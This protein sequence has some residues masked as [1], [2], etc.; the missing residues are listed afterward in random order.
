MSFSYA[1]S[2]SSHSTLQASAIW[3]GYPANSTPWR[4]EHMVLWCSLALAGAPTLLWPRHSWPRWRTQLLL[5]PLVSTPQSAS[6]V[7]L[8]C[9][10]V[11]LRSRAWLW[12][13]SRR[14]S[15]TASALSMRGNCK[16]RRNFNE[17]WRR[18]TL[19]ATCDGCYELC[20]V[21]GVV[22]GVGLGWVG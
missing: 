1:W 7:G 22:L 10:S 21:W 6:A 15:T 4:S 9:I 2:F 8:R 19:E 17:R 18:V 12:R 20:N 5:E 16:S 11:T 3:P 14:S 13:I